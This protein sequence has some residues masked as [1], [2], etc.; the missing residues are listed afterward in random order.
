[1]GSQRDFNSF[2]A[3]LTSENA[4][5]PPTATAP[6]L[7][8]FTIAGEFVPTERSNISVMY[9]PETGFP[10]L[11]KGFWWKVSKGKH[12]EINEP[13]LKVELM[14]DGAVVYGEWMVYHRGGYGGGSLLRIDPTRQALINRATEL[15]R[16]WAYDTMWEKAMEV[17]VGE[18]GRD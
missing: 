16:C 8:G 5:S 7:E 3:T 2:L 17:Q 13:T 15:Y 10:D 6:G 4:A 14:H 11:P 9:D 18:F 12:P 1:M